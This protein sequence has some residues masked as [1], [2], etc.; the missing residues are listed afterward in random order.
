M[1][2][3]IEIYRIL[4]IYHNSEGLRI[5]VNVHTYNVQ[6]QNKELIV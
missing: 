2:I 1:S 3:G 6:R 5:I 4:G